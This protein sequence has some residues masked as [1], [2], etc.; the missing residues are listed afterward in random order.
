MHGKCGNRLYSFHSEYHEG[1]FS[2]QKQKYNSDNK[3]LIKTI[4]FVW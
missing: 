4:T 1:H 3:L 2:G